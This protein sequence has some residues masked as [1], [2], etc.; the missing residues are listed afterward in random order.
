MLAF[1]SLRTAGTRGPYG[2]RIRAR[3]AAARPA[4]FRRRPVPAPPPPAGA[5]VPGPRARCAPSA[6]KALGGVPSAATR[7]GGLLG[8]GTV[9]RRSCGL[10]WPLVGPR[11]AAAGPLQAGPLGDDHAA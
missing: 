2:A 8:P 7:L 11:R 5:L 1:V 4:P 9:R 3:A 6:P 10:L